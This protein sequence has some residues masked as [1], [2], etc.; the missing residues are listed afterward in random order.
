MYKA[1]KRRTVLRARPAIAEVLPVWRFCDVEDFSY[2][3]HLPLKWNVLTYRSFKEIR[4]HISTM[5]EGE[6]LVIRATLIYVL[7]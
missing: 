1:S 2:Y 6:V 5:K 7:S 3:E 4:A